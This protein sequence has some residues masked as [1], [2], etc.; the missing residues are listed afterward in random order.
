MTRKRIFLKSETVDG[1][2]NDIER[3]LQ[4]MSTKLYK[5]TSVIIPPIPLSVALNKIPEDGEVFRGLFITDG[6]ISKVNAYCED[7][8]KDAKPEMSISVITKGVTSTVSFF[9]KRGFSESEFDFPVPAGS[10]VS[11]AVTEPVSITGFWAAAL[12]QMEVK[13]SAVKS[14]AIDN[15]LASSTLMLEEPEEPK[16]PKDSAGP[17]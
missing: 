13:D 16:E 12:Y 9:L 17:E 3:A 6:H 8:V 7:I 5:T 15:L 2:F 4:L 1:R 10:R 14:I 11:M